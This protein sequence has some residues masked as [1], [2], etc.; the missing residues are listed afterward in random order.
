MH[1]SRQMDQ[2]LDAPPLPREPRQPRSLDSAPGQISNR[3]PHEGYHMSNAEP[4]YGPPSTHQVRAVQA[5]PL[6]PTSRPVVVPASVPIVLAAAPAATSGE[7][8]GWHYKDP[9]GVDHGPFTLEEV[10]LGTSNGE[11]S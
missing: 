2:P 1:M 6:P 8:L 5:P 7:E 9:K 11:V 4:D 3:N 10:R